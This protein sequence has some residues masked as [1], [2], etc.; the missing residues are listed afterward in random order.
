MFKHKTVIITRD[1]TELSVDYEAYYYISKLEK[2][3][4]DRDHIISKLRHELESPKPIVKSEHYKP[5]L[6]TDC[7]DCKYVVRS[8]WNNSIIGCR[9]QNVC[10]D[11]EKE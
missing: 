1:E 3:L 6:S 10:E 2:E 4:S 8:P 7:G 11:F 9:K 5:A